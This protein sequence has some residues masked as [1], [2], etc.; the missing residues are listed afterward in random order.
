MYHSLSISQVLKEL[1]TTK[2]GL[3]Q[4][5]VEK[6]LKKYGENIL[7]KSGEKV[8]RL[9]IFLNQWKSPLLIILLVAGAVSGVLKEFIDMT[10]IFL[11]AGI[12]GIV[13]FIQEDK[14][15]KALSRL[16]SMIEYKATVLR[17]GIK[18]SLASNKVVPGDILFIEA[19]DRIQ[20]DGRILQSHN[21]QI[22]EAALTGESEAA[23]KKVG[24]L[25]KETV[26]GDRTNM[27]YRGTVATEGKATIVVTGT[28]GNTEIGK[29]ASMVK[30]TADEKTPL[31]KQLSRLAKLLGVAVLLMSTAIFVLGVLSPRERHGFFEMF[32]T[33]VAVAVAAIPEGLIISLTII[34]A[35][36]MQRILRKNALVRRLL[37]AE[38]LGSVSVICTDKTGTLTEGKMHVTYLVTSS[39]DL[40]FKELHAIDMKE[41]ERHPD[42]LKALKVGVMCNDGSLENPRDKTEN[43]KFIGDTTDTALVQAGMYVG[44]EK[45]HLDQVFRRSDEIPFDSSLQ[46]MATLHKEEQDSVIYTKGAG[47]KIIDFCSYYE[48]NGQKKKM[49]QKKLHWFREQEKRLTGQGFRVLALAYKK[50]DKKKNKLNKSDLTDMV[51]AGLVAL[52]DP[53]RP[54]VEQTIRIAQEAGIRIVMITGDHLRTAQSIARQIDLPCEDKHTMTGTDIEKIK[55]EKLRKLV[56]KIHVF[57]RVEPK[58]KIRIVRAFQVNDEVVA[59]T[60]DGVNDAPALKA[61]D[62]GIALGAGSDVS[63]ETSDMV[64]L[65][66]NVSTIVSAVEEGRTIY[67]NIRKVIVF[68]LSGS[69]SEVLLITSSLILGYPLAILPVQILWVNLIEDSF[70]NI[71]LA[72]DKGDKE[73]MKEPPRKKNESIFNKEMKSLI[74]IITIVSNFILIGLYLYFFHYY[75]GQLDLV[76]TMVFAALTIDSLFFILPVRSMNHMVWHINPFSNKYIIGSLVF[77]LIMLIT[78]IYWPP[79]QILLGT[80]PLGWFEWL[81]IIAFGVMNLALIELVKGFFLVKKYHHLR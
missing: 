79:L 24:R 61:A 62:M 45:H 57:A 70:P 6:R 35:I 81:V 60:G 78:S 34:L 37:S 15:S 14:A 53:L 73:N 42:A 33:A 51:L 43:W 18:K 11:S 21:L 47:E 77:G 20:A 75:E 44:L 40:N 25:K 3:K 9:K 8:S 31:Q 30:K 55:D 19:G 16:Q 69:F 5:Q 59:M 41:E 49:D 76:R 71:A 23:K 13:G 1:N 65:D 38:T 29:I 17:D 63:K 58:H 39:E 10:V 7:P 74:L 68:L 67:Q 66:N 54:D 36:G 48:H 46:Y 64:L 4:K 80:V 28:G 26:V 12:N 27:V 32:E 22:Q 2:Q 50:A 56:K 52:S 72:F